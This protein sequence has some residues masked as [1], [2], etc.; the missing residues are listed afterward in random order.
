MICVAVSFDWVT[1]ASVAYGG[2]LW[3]RA[4]S[5][6]EPAVPLAEIQDALRYA[7]D[8]AWLVLVADHVR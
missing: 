5:W 1:V 7:F 2:G 8:P 3:L 4:V 6:R